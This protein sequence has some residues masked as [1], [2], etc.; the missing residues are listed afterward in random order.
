MHDWAARI[1]LAL[2]VIALCWVTARFGAWAFSPQAGLYAGLALATCAGLFLFTRVLIPDAILALAVTVA[3]WSFLRALEEDEARSRFWSVILATTIA[4]GLLLK[5][6]LALIVIGGGAFFYLVFTRQLLSARIWRRLHPFQTVMIVLLI[7]APW[8]VMATLRNPPYLDFALHSERGTYRGFFW[9]FFINEHVLRFL[10]LRYPRD[11]DTVPRVYFWLFHLIWLLPWSVFI[12]AALRLNYTPNDRAGR[13]RLLALCWTGVLLVFFSFSTTQEYYSLPCYPALALL[14]G[15]ALAGGG[16]AVR[17]GIKTA[18]AVALAAAIAVALLLYAA[19]SYSTPG[20]ITAALTANP[21]AYTLSLGHMQDLTLRAFAYLRFPMILAGTAFLLG[22]AGAWRS[23]GQPAILALALMM[24]V[25]AH[26]ARL[27]LVTFDPYLSSKILADALLRAPPGDLIADD[28]YYAFS[29]VFFYANRSGLLLNGRRNNLEYGS[30][31]PG[32][33][34][35]FLDDAG[36]ARRWAGPGRCYLLIAASSVPRLARITGRPALRLV[37]ESGGK[38]LF[39][40][41]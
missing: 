12:P 9:F 2:C 5:G 19:R 15:S 20:D 17:I 7:A 18:G 37:V 16:R 33:P 31:A 3:L 6:L 40:N 14:L 11:Y 36:W 41:K 1:P 13:V 35:V 8:H 25:F 4:A 30:N 23:S 39:T 29:S 34:A 28:E 22:A 10:N 21:E 38:Y 32:A 26:A 27:A 24:V